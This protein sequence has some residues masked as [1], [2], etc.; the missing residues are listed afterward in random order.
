VVTVLVHVQA[1]A[2]QKAGP[3][4]WLAPQPI[5]DPAALPGLF[6]PSGAA[7]FDPDYPSQAAPN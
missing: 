4:R 7:S 5:N 1:I 2:L 6:G 3:R